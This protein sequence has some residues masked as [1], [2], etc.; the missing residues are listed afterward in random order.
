[1]LDV[2]LMSQ[3]QSLKVWW[4][5]N[6]NWQN[7]SMFVETMYNV[8]HIF[9]QV[10]FWTGNQCN[11]QNFDPSLLFY[12]CWLIFIGMKQIKRKLK[13]KYKKKWP[14]QKNW[15]FQL[16]QFSIF[17]AKISGIG[18]WVNRINWW[19]GHWFVHPI[20]LSGCST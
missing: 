11:H 9:R 20:W 10:L 14:T 15:D 19:E 18:P 7:Y 12:K 3:G 1:M 6:Q 8:L 16:P 13:K 2:R 17:F 5:K 4:K